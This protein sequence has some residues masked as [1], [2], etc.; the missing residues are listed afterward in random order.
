MRN[1]VVHAARVFGAGLV[2]SAPVIADDA[3]IRRNLAARLADLPKVDEISKTSIPGL[4]EVR[5]GNDIFYSDA[6]GDHLIQGSIVD[7]RSRGD[8]TQARINKLTAIDFAALPLK[9]AIVWRQGSG[10]RRLA[11]FADPNCGYC[12]RFEK[13]LNHVK[14]VTV[15]T[16]LYPILGGD[17]P[18]KS[19][20]IWCTKDQ[21]TVWRDWMIDGKTPPRSI[22]ACNTAALQRNAALGA[23]HRVNGTP[24]LVFEDGTRV[25]GALPAEKLEKQLI[26]SAAKSSSPTKR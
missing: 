21:A 25:S 4:F 14:D 10:T 24:T 2:F 3:A 1:A 9:D 5:I 22:G 6:N 11:V 26:D 20:D 19:R 15:Y 16:F 12:R 8:L 18:E 23:R 13:D 17:S 7:T